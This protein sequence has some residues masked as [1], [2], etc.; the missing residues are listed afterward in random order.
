MCPAYCHG[1]IRT[2]GIIYFLINGFYSVNKQ[3]QRCVYSRI[4]RYRP[5]AFAST[6]EIF[7]L[8]NGM[9]YTQVPSQGTL[10]T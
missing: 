6:D 9:N 3:Q 1:D 7:P 8:A 10:T 5:T 2:S 4:S